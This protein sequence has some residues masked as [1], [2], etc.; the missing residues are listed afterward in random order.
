MDMLAQAAA[1]PSPRAETLRAGDGV[2]LAA[3]RFEG[4]GPGL[5]LA[6]GFGQT[7][8]AWRSTQQR[9]AEAGR[10]S[11][12]WD[13]RGH[14]QSA[15]N[16]V[17]SRYG[18][19]QFVDD[20]TV[21][22]RALGPAP[23][24]V[25]AS[26]GGLTGLMAQARDRV[27][28]ALVLVDITPRWEAAGVERILGFMTAH[29]DGFASYEHAA[30]EIAAYLPHRRE[31]KSPA[32]LAHL[33][34]RREDGRLGWHWDP[35]LLTEFIPDTDCLQHVIEDACRALD[36]P[37]LLVSGGRSDLVTDR[38]VQHFMELA[39]H[40]RHVQLPQATHM[41]AGDDNS[42]FTDTLLHFLHDL[43]APTAAHGDPR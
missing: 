16:P 32:Q 15:R 9:L 26:M 29:P 36:V 18:G 31:K 38:T 40:A 20:V 37:V 8:Q 34:V 30:A 39:P 11:L 13:V 10:A 28:S 21:A 27:F 25:G 23:I 17:S 35:R 1:P 19:G 22:A 2:A 33:L 5:L 41:V 7:R 14:G 6:H 24:L 3:E 43:P 42:A 12:S 4:A